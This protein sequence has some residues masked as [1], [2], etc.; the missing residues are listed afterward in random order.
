M[1]EPIIK[2]IILLSEAFE[3]YAIEDES[4][5]ISEMKTIKTKNS[6]SIKVETSFPDKGKVFKTSIS[7]ISKEIE[8][9][10]INFDYKASYYAEYEDIKG[11]F[12]KLTP[13]EKG[14]LLSKKIYNDYI[15]DNVEAM[16][17]KADIKGSK[18][19]RLN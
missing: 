2:R 19:N 12:E 11:E 13:E 16:L 9:D 18:L 8:T 3:Q 17:N 7:L 1:M 14:S 5:D 10:H 6:Q 15:I 4:G